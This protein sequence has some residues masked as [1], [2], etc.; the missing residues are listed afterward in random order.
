ML[1][2]AK[3]KVSAE[4]LS[5]VETPEPTKSHTP[6]AH[7]ELVD[8]TR[9]ALGDS[10]LEITSEEHGLS[11]GSQR[12]FGG[13]AITG[14]SFLDEKGDS[15]R[16]CHSKDRK[17]VLGLRNS[18]D[19]SISAGIAVGNQMLVCDNL[20]FSSDVTLARKHTTYIM[21]DLYNRIT[22]AISQVTSHWTAMEDRIETYKKTEV[23]D[24][25]KL[26]LDLFNDNVL[27]YKR[28]VDA[29]QEFHNPRHEEFKGGSL[30]TLYNA[31]T[32]SLKGVGSHD[33]SNRTMKMQA[34]FDYSANF[35]P[36]QGEII[37]Q[38]DRESA[39][40]LPA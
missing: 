37:S 3:N 38:E 17:L 15:K 18:H 20:C 31:I 24:A 4:Q 25:S 13:F 34:V 12:Y 6:I 9:K 16:D 39:L 26:I 36:F 23:E 21:N 7:H 35:T 32:E 8:M 33:I 27:G 29:L 2:Y 11:H 10:G 22:S 28:A 1:I 5:K 40:V 19:K 14:Q 30:W